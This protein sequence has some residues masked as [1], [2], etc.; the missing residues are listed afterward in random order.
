MSRRLVTSVLVW[1]A[2]AALVPAAVAGF[3]LHNCGTAH[4]PALAADDSDCC[5]RVHHVHDEVVHQGRATCSAVTI[6]LPA[7]ASDGPAPAATEPPTFVAHTPEGDA[8][9][10]RHE[11]WLMAGVEGTLRFRPLRN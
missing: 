1:W 11:P 7:L 3:S 4:A 6:H 9:S 10:W 5:E 2:V 8:P